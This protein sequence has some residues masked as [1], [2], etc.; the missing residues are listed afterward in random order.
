MM[1]RA[2]K[3]P[4]DLR[5][6][7]GDRTAFAPTLAQAKKLWKELFM[8]DKKI[9]TFGDI[10]RLLGRDRKTTITAAAPNGDELTGMGDSV[11]WMPMEDLPVFG[12]EVTAPFTCRV[13]L[14]S[15]NGEA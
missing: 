11:L 3:E 1:G 6:S 8:D 4:I 5:A 9:I 7:R 10:L 15:I 13:T 12:L 14:E 2:V